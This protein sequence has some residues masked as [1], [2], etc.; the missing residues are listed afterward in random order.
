MLENFFSYLVQRYHFIISVSRSE[1]YLIMKIVSTKI[2][3][4]K[5][6]MLPSIKKMKKKEKQK[7][8]RRRKKKER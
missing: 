3:P 1:S 5:R 4:E 7:K 6:H 8:K 2:R